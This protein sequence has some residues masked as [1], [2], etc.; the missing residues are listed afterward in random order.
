MKNIV[1]IIAL[2]STMCVFGQQEKERILITFDDSWRTEM[3]PMPL[4]FAPQI[5][6]KGMEEVRFSK[7]WAQK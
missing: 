5:P 7:G 4:S 3:I 6:L 1:Y 2:F